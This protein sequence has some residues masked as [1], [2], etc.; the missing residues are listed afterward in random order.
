MSG[1]PSIVVLDDWEHSFRRLADW[2][3]IDAKADVTV[4]S[5]S[6]HGAELVDALC[7]A[8]VIVL[9]RDRTPFDKA[10]LNQLPHLEYVIY[11]GPRNKKLDRAAL[12]ERNIP[13]SYTE[14]GPARQSTCEHT[15]ALILASMRQLES[16]MTQVRNGQWRPE[17]AMTLANV[18]SG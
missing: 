9:H 1:Q 18:L 16:Q 12:A 5:V 3:P 15:W 11:T 8:N 14:G 10:L 7:Q 17:A 13:V 4:H 6:L 2:G